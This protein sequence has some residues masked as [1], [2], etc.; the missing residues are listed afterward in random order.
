MVTAAELVAKARA[1]RIRE[2]TVG[3]LTLHVRR[4]TGVERRQL[5]ER[6]RSGNPMQATE[7]VALA[8]CNADGSPFLTG[9]EATALD[10]AD[11]ELLERMAEEVLRSAGLYEKAVE[12]ALKNSKATQNG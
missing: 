3:E 5:G 7:L 4:L 2:F 12:V 1:E 9:E 6:A 8:I 10:E 11:P